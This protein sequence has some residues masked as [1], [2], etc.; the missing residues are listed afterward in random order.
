[1]NHIAR[2]LEDGGWFSERQPDVV[3]PFYALVIGL[4]PTD[5]LDVAQ[6]HLERALAEARARASIPAIAFLTAH[7]GWFSL[8]A[9]AVAE[10]EAD[11]RATLELMSTHGIRLGKHF[12]L[13]LLIEVLIEYGQL[14][15]AESALR[16]NTLD[17][18]IPAGLA[19][20]H[21]SK[22]AG[23]C[24]SLAVKPARV[25]TISS[26]S[27]DA[28]SCGAARIRWPRAGAH[29]RAS[30]SPRSAKSNPRDA[31]PTKSSFAHAA[32]EPRAR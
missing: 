1:V 14:D 5:A 20:N 7:R 11:A 31:W 17:T 19:H 23:H 22:R 28:T 32:G 12:A 3:G 2:A 26:S 6:R 30:H 21:C 9:G 8:R 4:L 13:A 27:D 29:A 16:D 10:A 18:Q 15:A 24:A 25:S